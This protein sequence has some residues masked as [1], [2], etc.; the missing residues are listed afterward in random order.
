MRISDLPICDSIRDI[1]KHQ[2]NTLVKV[3]GVVTRRTSVYPQLKTVKFDCPKCGCVWMGIWY[4]SPNEMYQ[5]HFGSCSPEQCRTC[6]NEFVCGMWAQEQV[7]FPYQYGADHLQKLPEDD[8]PGIH[9]L[10]LIR[11]TL[12]LC[13][14]RAQGQSQL[15]ASPGQRM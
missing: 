15:V 14:R 12:V 8:S 4:V 5:V 3:S 11:V 1:R 7:F 2:L 10:T 6:Q 9:T 13:C